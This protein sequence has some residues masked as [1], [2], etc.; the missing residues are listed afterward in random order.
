MSGRIAPAV[1]AMEQ[2]GVAFQLFYDYGPLAD[3]DWPSGGASAQTVSLDR[4]QDPR[5]TRRRRDRCAFVFWM[6]DG[7]ADGQS[8]YSPY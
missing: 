2:A 8:E 5:R 4:L 3:E 6:R 1:R 7:D